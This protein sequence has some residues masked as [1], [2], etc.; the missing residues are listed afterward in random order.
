MQAS[1]PSDGGEKPKCGCHSQE[2]TQK[3]E[4]AKGDITLRINFILNIIIKKITIYRT[5]N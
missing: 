4:V 5:P 2:P 1:V 3:D